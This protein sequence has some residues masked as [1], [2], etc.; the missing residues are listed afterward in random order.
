M[1]VYSL[2]GMSC[3]KCVARLQNA[4]AEYPGAEVTLIPPQLIIPDDVDPG[5]A[6]LAA[7]ISAI[8]SGRYAIGLATPAADAQDAP[9][10]F[11]LKTYYPLF[12]I[13]GFISV[14]AMRGAEGLHDWMVHFMAGF[15][16]V[17]SFFKFLNLKGFAE[18]YAS[19]DLLAKRWPAYGY[20]YPF[21]ELGLGLC[22][23]FRINLA[24][25]LV[26]TIVLMGYSSLGV[27]KAVLSKRQIRCACL[28][29]TLNLPMSTITIVE[30]IG[31]VLMAFFMLL[32]G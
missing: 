1:S 22:Y 16:L 8:E 15:F 6:V 10:R 7:K 14:A 19:Y 20:I 17:F 2:S 21:L 13:L 5:M 11:E 9:A 18:A 24:E 30:D 28:G 32:G 3:G 23:L 31:M 27:I 26:F 12:L 4:V 25:T 29:T